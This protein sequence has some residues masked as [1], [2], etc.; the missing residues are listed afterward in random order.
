MGVAQPP[1]RGAKLG[2][3][4]SLAA[5]VGRYD[6]PILC[7]C[8][9]T[10]PGGAPPTAPLRRVEAAADEPDQG[11]EAKAPPD[12]RGVQTKLWSGNGDAC[13]RSFVPKWLPEQDSNLR[14]I[15]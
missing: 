4:R 9:R 2:L 12:A 11:N 5:I 8:G 13:V 14:P 7:G 6:K 10:G 15:D 1:F 3:L